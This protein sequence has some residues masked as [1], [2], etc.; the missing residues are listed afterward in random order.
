[1]ERRVTGNC[2]ARCEAGEKREITSNSY[3]SLFGFSIRQYPTGKTHTG[4]NSNGK[5]LGYNTRITPSKTAIKQHTHEI[6]RLLRKLVSAPQEKVIR[7][8][9]PV[10]RGWTNY[11][12]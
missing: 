2:H 3:L 10:I 11:Y 5:L 1:M 7:V 12:K 4:K 6:K 8:L 9:N